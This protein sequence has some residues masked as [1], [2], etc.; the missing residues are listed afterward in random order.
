VKVPD[1]RQQ[2]I[3]SYA[4][5]SRDRIFYR[6]ASVAMLKHR[7]SPGP[8]AM[9]S[10]SALSLLMPPSLAL[11]QTYRLSPF[12][13]GGLPSNIQGTAAALGST[14]PVAVAVD[15]SGNVYFTDDNSSVTVADVQLVI[16]E[17]L[18]SS[19]PL[20]DLNQDGAVNVTDVQIAV[21][22]ALGLGCATP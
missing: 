3:E 7:C 5:M 11:A 1:Y 18:G 14:D 6:H 12:A 13:G 4:A 17:T 10:L 22:S 21:N 16:N 2:V 8:G 15:S 9:W 20:A 19:P